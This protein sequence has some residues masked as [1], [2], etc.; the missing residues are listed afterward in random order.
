MTGLAN[1]LILR[2]HDDASSRTLFPSK[3]AEEAGKTAALPRHEA[4]VGV[5]FGGGA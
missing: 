3:T 1:L 5:L 2:L 4:L